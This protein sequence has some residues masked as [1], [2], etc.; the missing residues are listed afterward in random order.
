MRNIY[1]EKIEIYK[2]R[3]GEREELGGY[4][5]TLVDSTVE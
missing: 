3:E 5:A 4:C 2:E 1:N